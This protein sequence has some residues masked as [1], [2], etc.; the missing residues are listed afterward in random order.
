MIPGLQKLS[1]ENVTPQTTEVLTVQRL[2]MARY[3]ELFQ[4]ILLDADDKCFQ[5]DMTESKREESRSY[6]EEELKKLV[7][8]IDKLDSAEKYLA[9]HLCNYAHY[10]CRIALDDANVNSRLPTAKEFLN[11]KLRKTPLSQQ[12]EISRRRK[13]II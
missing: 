13:A 3:I 5:E 6:L 1:I 9:N 7:A 4:G 8:E 12:I 2:A 10:Y 11:Q